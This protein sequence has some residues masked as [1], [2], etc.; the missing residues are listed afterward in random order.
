MTMTGPTLKIKAADMPLKA[1]GYMCRILKKVLLFIS[2]VG[3]VGG[4]GVLVN[5][6]SMPVR[7]QE[8][9][10]KGYRPHLADLMNDAMQIHHTK[11]WFAGHANNWVLADYEVKKIKD[12]IEE[13]KET[14]V[15]IQTASPQWRRVPLG[16]ML[17]R[18]DSNLV[19]LEQAVKAKDAVRFAE[20]YGKL[21]MTCNACHVS[22]GQSQ[23]KIIEPL[24]NGSG[25]FADQDFTS[26]TG[27]Q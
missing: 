25:T 24:T 26:S 11:L 14:I 17:R 9:K 15:E 2:M 10:A 5:L 8:A 12:T 3:I 19:S 7:A 1:G 13:L 6:Y 21:T 16:E 22:S 20:S 4:T 27:R 23:V 18:F